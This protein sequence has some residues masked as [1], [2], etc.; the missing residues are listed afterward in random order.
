MLTAQARK[1][2][3]ILIRKAVVCPNDWFL[4]IN[5]TDVTMVGSLDQRNLSGFAENLIWVNPS[6]PFPGKE[7]KKGDNSVIRTLLSN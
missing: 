3:D 1:C 2:L 7:K 4:E 5:V 6:S